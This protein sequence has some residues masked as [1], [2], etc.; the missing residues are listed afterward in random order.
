[1]ERSSRSDLF[2]VVGSSLVV[3]PAASMPQYAKE[4]GAKL[5]I[6]NLSPTPYDKLADIIVH[7][8]A[9]EGMERIIGAMGLSAAAR[10]QG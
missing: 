3:Y 4:G 6:M 10:G 9:G 8:S 2:I 7:C 5:V 1:V